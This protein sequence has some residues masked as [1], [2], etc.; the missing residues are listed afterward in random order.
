MADAAEKTASYQDLLRVPAHQVAEIVRGQ[1]VTHP[2]PGPRHAQA[3]S[4]LGIKVGGGYDLGEGGP[5]GWLILDEP[6]LHLGPHVLVP[7]LAGWRRERLPTLPETAWF[8]LA[9]DWVCEVL[10]PATAR[11][12]RSGK[13]PIYAEYGVQWLWLVDPDLQTL[14]VYALQDG[15]WLLLATLSED[16]PVRQP[17]FDAIEFP[18]S[19][20]WP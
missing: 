16:A 5:G 13:M 15:H 19:A 18:L 14:E 9:P 17:P 20:L 11:T 10:S 12:D 7:D 8:E 2:R 1:L 6:E 4:R 3:A